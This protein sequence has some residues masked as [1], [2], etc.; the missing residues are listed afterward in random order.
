[1]M[2]VHTYCLLSDV[3]SCVLSH[4]KRPVVFIILD[5]IH[6][7]ACQRFQEVGRVLLCLDLQSGAQAERRNGDSKE[8]SIGNRKEDEEEKRWDEDDEKKTQKKLRQ[9]RVLVIEQCMQR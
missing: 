7:V 5:H 9:K 2:Y 1:M 3:S 4:L 6:K 8:E